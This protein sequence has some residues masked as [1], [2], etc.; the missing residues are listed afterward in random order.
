L[1]A[2][3]RDGQEAGW[4]SALKTHYH[5]ANTRRLQSQWQSWI[6][7]VDRVAVQ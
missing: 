2:F 3:A 4:D 1:L 6:S 5:I 7:Q